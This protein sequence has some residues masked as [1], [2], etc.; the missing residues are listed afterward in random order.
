MLQGLFRKHQKQF[1]NML[2]AGLLCLLIESIVFLYALKI[3]VE[4]SNFLQTTAS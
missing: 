2:V 1:F 3:G 4:F